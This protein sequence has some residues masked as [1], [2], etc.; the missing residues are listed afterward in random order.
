MI[1]SR[2]HFV[3]Q[4]DTATDPNKKLAYAPPE[5][6]PSLFGKCIYFVRAN[7]S[8][9]VDPKTVDSDLVF[10]EIIGSPIQACLAQ[11]R[12]SCACAMSVFF[13][14]ASRGTLLPDL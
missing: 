5:K 9:A 8:K 1:N 6:Q 10:G 14:F 13:C 7:A 2:M 3:M 12:E 4:G 11:A